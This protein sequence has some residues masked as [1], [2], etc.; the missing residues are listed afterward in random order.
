MKNGFGKITGMLLA[1]CLLLG[2]CGVDIPT[3]EAD[4]PANVPGTTAPAGTRSPETAEQTLAP[5]T[6]APA[7]SDPQGGLFPVETTAP[8]KD[9]ARESVWDK[10]ISGEKLDIPEKAFSGGAERCSAIAPDGVTLLMS[11]GAAPYLYNLET[12]KRTSLVP[13]DEATE[14]YLREMILA[15]NAIA[16]KATEEQTAAMRER[17]AKMKGAE[18]TAELCTVTGRMSPLRQYTGSFYTRENYLFFV[19][20]GYT[21]LML[22]DCETG[23][24]YS[25]FERSMTPCGFQDGK[26]LYFLNPSPVLKLLDLKSGETEEIAI[27]APSLFPDGAR[28]RAAAFLPDGSLCAVLA[29]MKLDMENGENCALAV[30]SSDGKTESWLLG[31]VRYSW[32]PDTILASGTDCIIAYSRQAVRNS[33][34][35]L[36]RR[37][38]GEVLRLISTEEGLVQLLST[39]EY[40]ARY[41]DKGG[42][43]IG[44]IPLDSLADNETLLLQNM[45]A[46]GI[47]LLFRPS[48]GQS[49]MLVPGL[50]GF[51]V[52]MYYSSNHYDRFMD[53]GYLMEKA[54]YQLNFR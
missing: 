37:T 14:E 16:V 6:K 47:L 23:R 44:I 3:K 50:E 38:A 7:P 52:V 26:L 5:E 19:D 1:V 2:A 25:A 33:A 27:E 29:D 49:R 51:P 45:A 35:Y 32:E 28:L 54:Y 12:K 36:V 39:E 53:A 8:E 34:P 10:K 46:V 4:T 21:A 20:A 43:E 18:L 40:I 9:P 30:R 48:D 22:I 31:K 13:A 24:F 41:P 17:L 42:A 15:R 11:G